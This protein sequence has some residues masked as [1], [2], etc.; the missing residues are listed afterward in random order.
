MREFKPLNTAI[1]IGPSAFVPCI[2]S[3]V[4]PPSRFPPHATS[5]QG[6]RPSCVFGSFQSA[7]NF[8]VAAGGCVGLGS[9]LDPS[10][11]PEQ[12]EIFKCQARFNPLETKQQI[13]TFALKTDEW[14]KRSQVGA[15]PNMS[16]V[17]V[18][19]GWSRI[20]S[21]INPLFSRDSAKGRNR[22]RHH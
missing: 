11:P 1:K 8:R 16:S 19:A 20:L 9:P 18:C 15:A 22:P 5:L 4:D 3:G 2:T 6:G 7:H 12:H 17:K 10:P 13:N 14:V 21:L